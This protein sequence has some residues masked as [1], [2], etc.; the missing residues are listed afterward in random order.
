MPDLRT[1]VLKRAGYTADQQPEESPDFSDVTTG[2]APSAPHPMQGLVMPAMNISGAMPGQV[3]PQTQAAPGAEPGPPPPPQAPTPSGP[4]LEALQAVQREG[5]RNQHLAHQIAEYRRAEATRLGFNPEMV[6]EGKIYEG[7]NGPLRDMLQQQAFVGEQQKQSH[8][9]AETQHLGQQTQKSAQD[10]LKQ[11]QDMT[12]GSKTNRARAEQLNHVAQMFGVPGVDPIKFTADQEGPLVKAIEAKASLSGHEALAR[13][14]LAEAHS[15]LEETKHQ[16]GVEAGIQQQRI[17]EK[18]AEAAKKEKELKQP[19]KDKLDTA[20][21]SLDTVEDLKK[22]HGDIGPSGLVPGIDVGNSYD[23]TKAGENASGTLG[24]ALYPTT[25]GTGAAELVRKRL[26]GKGSGTLGT[27]GSAF[28]DMH[29]QIYDNADQ[30]LKGLEADPHVDQAIVHAYR[31]QLEDKRQMY[32]IHS[33][34]PPPGFVPGL[35]K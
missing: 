6:D 15:R 29:K 18:A 3:Q 27:R 9:M 21:E 1:Q 16:H 14:Q 17:D 12:P 7:L 8:Q 33:E 13:A 11:W 26:P 25:R 10:V 4:S 24:K 23:Y 5:Y 2:G 31:K 32:G 28:D 30:T 34:K 22:K 20:L 19:D 35:P